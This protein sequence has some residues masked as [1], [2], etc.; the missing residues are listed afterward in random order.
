MEMKKNNKLTISY[1]SSSE[2][3]DYLVS[4]SEKYNMTISGVL[5]MIVMQHKF[6]QESLVKIETLNTLVE[7]FGILNEF[8]KEEINIEK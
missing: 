6:Q 7:K 1:S 5:T 2:I 4:L 3:K 8:E